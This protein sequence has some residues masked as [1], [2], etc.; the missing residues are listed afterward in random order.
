MLWFDLEPLCSPVPHRVGDG[1][2][3]AALVGQLVVT[4]ASTWTHLLLVD[5]TVALEQLET[6]GEQRFADA[7]CAVHE[8]T[9]RPAPGKEIPDDDWGP[10]L[11]QQL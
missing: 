8:L 3:V 10:T 6:L 4:A 11:G 1:F 9:E 5:D 2:E 7:W